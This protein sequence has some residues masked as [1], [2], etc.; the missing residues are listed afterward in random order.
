MITVSDNLAGFQLGDYKL[1]KCIGTGGM[2]S[3]YTG[4]RIDTGETAAVK[5]MLPEYV[6]DEEFRNR[7]K[8][9]GALLSQLNHPNII[10]VYAVGEENGYLFFAMRYVNGVSLYDL[11]QRRHFS[12]LSVWQILNPVAKALDYA[13]SYNVIHRDIKPGNILIEV[14]QTDQGASNLVFLADFGLSKV[15]DWTK[16]TQVGISVG[17]P[18]Y[19]SPEQVMDEPLTP[20]SDVYSLAVVIYEMILGRW[21][22]YDK[23]SEKVA[24]KHVTE[25]PPRPSTLNP[26]FPLPLEQVLLKALSKKPHERYSSAGEFGNAYTEAVRQISAEDRKDDFYVGPPSGY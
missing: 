9:E 12:P 20:A 15:L 19:M 2:G 6:K 4:E 3:V 26:A 16:L 13:H 14:L 23:R 17:T 8:R 1:T 21:L 11:M 18:E 7:F 22:F 5:V 10:P 25:K 24:F